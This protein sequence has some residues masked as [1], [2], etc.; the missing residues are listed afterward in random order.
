MKIELNAEILIAL[1]VAL[2]ELS[3]SSEWR[4]CLDENE[5]EMVDSGINQLT[6]IVNQYLH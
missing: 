2:D 3:N 5:E 4:Y 1:Q 6:D